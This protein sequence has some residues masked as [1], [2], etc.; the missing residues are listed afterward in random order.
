MKLGTPG[1]KK[2]EEGQEKRRHSLF[3][4]RWSPRA[5]TRGE[6]ELAR[7]KKKKRKKKEK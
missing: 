2:K 5:P 7:E 1:K 6:G 4:A 3:L